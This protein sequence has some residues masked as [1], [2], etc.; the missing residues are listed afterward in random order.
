VLLARESDAFAMHS[1]ASYHVKY[2]CILFA[3]RLESF[4]ALWNIVKEIFNLE[5]W[6]AVVFFCSRVLEP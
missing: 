4:L 1:V 2:L 3:G 6:S 5:K